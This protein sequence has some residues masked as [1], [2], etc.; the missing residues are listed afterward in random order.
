MPKGLKNRLHADEKMKIPA[1]YMPKKRHV[2]LT[3]WWFRQQF[4]KERQEIAWNLNDSGCDRCRHETDVFLIWTR[5]CEATWSQRKWYDAHKKARNVWH[6]PMTGVPVWRSD[7]DRY[8]R[9]QNLPVTATD[10]GNCRWYEFK[11]KLPG[12]MRDPARRAT[13][14]LDDFGLFEC[15]RSDWI[16]LWFRPLC[17]DDDFEFEF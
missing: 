4:A 17:A 13:C 3:V 5:I 14:L 2:R 7:T 11:F 12:S 9:T 1:P 8:D 10:A 16:A 6:M 15:R